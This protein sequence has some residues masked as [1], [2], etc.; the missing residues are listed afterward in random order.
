MSVRWKFEILFKTRPDTHTAVS[1]YYFTFSLLPKLPLICWQSF[2]LLIRHTANEI[3]YLRPIFYCRALSKH[4]VC[5]VWLKRS[6]SNNSILR[7]RDFICALTFFL[8]VKQWKISGWSIGPVGFKPTC[9]PQIFKKRNACQAS[10]ILI[11]SPYF[12]R[13]LSI[14]FL[15]ELTRGLRVWRRASRD[16]LL[17]CRV[18]GRRQPWRLYHEQILT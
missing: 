4:L 11:R 5:C 6:I 8:L 3:L 15:F 17:D 7:I 10:K 9:P 16:K 14:S 13:M 18:S 12:K 1:G 2:P